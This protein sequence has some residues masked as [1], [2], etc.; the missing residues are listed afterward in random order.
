[1]ID[2]SHTRSVIEE[3][4]TRLL[5]LSGNNRLLNFKASATNCLRIVDE[6]PDH[7]FSGLMA[8][9]SFN[10]MPVPH[11]TEN[12]IVR[13]H[14][15]RTAAPRAKV[16]PATLQ[17]PKPEELAQHLGINI[18]FELPLDQGEQMEAR[19]AD[20]KVQSLLYP[21]PLDTRLRKLR[22]DASTAIEETGTNFLHLAI[23]FLDW[24]E[25]DGAGS[26]GSLAPLILV[27]VEI[28]QKRSP[29]GH[30]IYDFAWS[31]EDLQPNLSLQKKLREEFGLDLPDLG[32]DMLPERYFQMVRDLVRH[33]EGWLVRRFATLSLFQFGK[34]LIYRD[35]DPQSWPQGSE[36]AVHP[37]IRHITSGASGGG[38]SF[39]DPPPPETRV[40][41]LDLDLVE[42]ADSSQAG[43]IH[44]ALGGA[45]MVIQGP[46]GTGKSQTI[47][48]LI[49]GALSAGKTVLF[50]SEKL[51]ALEVVRDRLDALGLGDFVLELHSNKTR[52]A[53]L[54]DDLRHRVEAG[55]SFRPSRDF[56]S[57][58]AD[59]A[60]D[61]DR[62]QSIHAAL[63]RTVG[64]L[65]IPTSKVL[66]EAGRHRR[67]LRDPHRIGLT[68]SADDVGRL[69]ETALTTAADTLQDFG[70][71][72]APLFEA[73]QTLKDHPFAGLSASRI[74]GA[75]DREEVVSFLQVW[76]DEL[77]TLSDRAN[78]L[79]DRLNIAPPASRQEIATWTA[80][81]S[82]REEIEETLV[83]IDR[84]G[85]L[86]DQITSAL[87]LS[88][89]REPR[90][91]ALAAK[92][93]ELV[94]ARPAELRRFDIAMLTDRSDEDRRVELIA[95]LQAL[96][97]EK[98]D[99]GARLDLDAAFAAAGRL[100]ELARTLEGGGLFR[101]LKPAWRTARNQAKA[102]AAR[103]G[104]LEMPG[105]LRS[106]ARVHGR[107]R[108]LLADGDLGRLSGAKEQV[109]VEGALRLL[110][111]LGA[112]RA[113]A[114]RIEA[115]FGRGFSKD[116]RVARA[117]LELGASESADMAAAARTPE[118]E[119]LREI[120][121]RLAPMLSVTAGGRAH[122]VREAVLSDFGSGPATALIS[123][124]SSEERHAIFDD[125]QDL[126]LAADA[127]GEAGRI[128][129]A[130][131][132]LDEAFWPYSGGDLRTL[133]ARAERALA[134]A[135]RLSE[136]LEIDRRLRRIEL[137]LARQV[138]QAILSRQI[139]PLAA[140]RY[141]D[142]AVMDGLARLALTQSPILRE[143]GQ[144]EIDVARR[145]YAEQ[146]ERTMD[147]RAIDIAARL[148][149]RRVPEGHTGAR[150]A[151]LTDLQLLKREMAKKTQHVPIRQLVRRAGHA[152]QALKPCFMMGPMSV[153][154]YLQPGALKFDL[155][156][157]D[158][159]S[160]VRPEEALGA[161][162]RGEQAVIVGDSKQLP[163]TDFFQRTGD[164]GG[165][166][167]A[168]AAGAESILEIAEIRLPTR[169]LRWHYR[170]QH[171]DLIAFS[172]HEFYK[173]DLVL[174]P[175][176]VQA[177][178]DLGIRFQHVADGAFRDGTNPTEAAAVAR[179]VIDHLERYPGDSLGVVAMN[180][181][182]RD[183]ILEILERI[184]GDGQGTIDAA[185]ELQ[186]LQ[187]R[188]FVKNL[189]NVQGDER[190]SIIISMTYGPPAPGERVAQS[191]GPI[192]FDNGW[193]RLNVLFSRAKKRMHI[194]SSM[195]EG[196][197]Q[198]GETTKRGPRALKSFLHFAE[199]GRLDRS[200]SATKW[201]GHGPDSDF[202]VAVMEGLSA[203]GYECVPQVGSSGFFIDIGVVDRK[204]PDR[205]LVGIECDG[206]SYHSTLSARDRDRLRQDI[207][208]SKG[209]AI[210]RV[211][212]TD[213][214][215]D[216]DRELGRLLG[217]LRNIEAMT[218]RR[219]EIRV[220]SEDPQP[221]GAVRD[222]QA[223]E[224]PS[225]QPELFEVTSERAAKAEARR[226]A[227]SRKLSSLTQEEGRRLLIELRERI[228][229]E[230]PAYDRA[231]SVLRKSMI[232]ELL[233]KK[234][235]DEEEFR[236]RIRPD[237]RL[238]TKGS[239]LRDHGEAIFEI[240]ERLR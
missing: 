34:L 88:E 188:F 177:S 66:F 42:R 112:C 121:E 123:K 142:F 238:E 96:S 176:P 201:N 49:A 115:V 84:M 127:E 216:P 18:S 59:L 211:W 233:S 204:R 226:P 13:W 37:V 120:G 170:S 133:R 73:G 76:Q 218:D 48:N 11:P 98:A 30:H 80:F 106:A 78:Q 26:K 111:Q 17:P 144:S 222:E 182:Q 41:D 187:E 185:E 156:I 132:G 154:Q 159:A 70:T 7:L 223:V 148:A 54:I 175:S 75:P 102:M 116:A 45:N 147:L 29:K 128:F 39:Q 194:V 208:E 108:N 14:D 71:V 79:G 158:E 38:L 195:R 63:S 72:A 57:K 217:R 61:R 213:W 33:R 200:P 220:P 122:S 35:L 28:T 162:A 178:D 206:A 58:A 47:T 103:S 184:H 180:V 82:R 77:A 152:L 126:A 125:L 146:D 20:L 119:A 89:D 2:V 234:P 161:L 145:R 53:A 199:T 92:V 124:M 232:G 210:E 62:T 65:E 179:A 136:W 131:T 135:E 227:M 149:R 6:M 36:P 183:L 134:E 16:D 205:F 130:R 193:R 157:F 138:L 235:L 143:L 167:A 151:D 25:A 203:A 43:A 8:G 173:G 87:G 197:V 113:Y 155:V 166:D 150:V 237:L 64:A 31:G 32:E 46:P 51:A 110:E 171:P 114:E 219:E 101:W 97:A 229:A 198:P 55:P 94:D 236:I 209:W 99:L 189:E 174:Y 212:S 52:K 5:D 214:F 81:L 228:A 117:L 196:D 107:E 3:M 186:S 192:N 140:A 85:E 56:A 239:E 40:L 139:E 69:D 181:K 202:E 91:V 118:G 141:F 74:L 215:R 172:N 68:I 9:R 4:R 104:S 191:F 230:N 60:R 164:G 24:R 153:A 224:P 15:Q 1:M 231:T 95:A 67:A 100:D 109:G 86:P 225:L 44:A 129:A 19:H 105:L 22:S 12:D 163:P 90:R 50:V 240:L 23:G 190:D 27:P 168:I 169:S 165:E 21:A 207:L 10:F 93:L 160:Q 221:L 83:A 137:P